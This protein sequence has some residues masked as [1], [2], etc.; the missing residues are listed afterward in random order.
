VLLEGDAKQVV[1]EVNVVGPNLQQLANL[2]QGFKKNY[3]A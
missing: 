2:L 1:I 3:K